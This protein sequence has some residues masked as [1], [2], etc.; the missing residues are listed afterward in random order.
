MTI[1]PPPRFLHEIRSDSPGVVWVYR[2]PDGCIEIGQHNPEDP[3]N[4]DLVHLC[5]DGPVRELI[6]ALKRAVDS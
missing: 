3:S 2:Q 1:D 6:A 4:P 5:D